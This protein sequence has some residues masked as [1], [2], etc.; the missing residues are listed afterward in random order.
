MRSRECGFAIASKLVTNTAIVKPVSETIGMIEHFSKGDR[1]RKTLRRLLSIA[2]QLQRVAALRVRANAGIVTAELVTEV[3]VT[4]HVIKCEAAP[5][6]FQRVGDIA[7]KKS[8]RPLAMIRFEQLL[9]I[10]GALRERHEFPGPVTRQSGLAPEIGVDPQAPF[11]LERPRAVPQFL[12]DFAGPGVGVLHLRTLQAAHDDK[13]R[14]EL[15]QKTQLSAQPILLRQASGQL[16][17]R[18]KMRDRF[19]IGRTAHGLIAGAHA[20]IAGGSCQ[21]GLTE[22]IGQQ[23]RFARGNVGEMFFKRV[24]DT[25][26]PFAPARQKQ[27]LIGDVTYQ[28]MLEA[29]APFLAALLGK[30]NSRRRKLRQYRLELGGPLG[31]NRRE[32][33][34]S[35]LPPDDGGNLGPFARLAEAVETGHQRILQRRRHRA[36]FARRFH[37]A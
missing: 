22:M 36:V 11:G 5:A 23:V 32:Q 31:G 33:R 20:I 29:E 12:A 30:D 3:T 4:V 28:C 21:A 37:D 13:R 19:R 24:G 35:K 6:A 8:R 2:G 16:E 10:A 26:M 34:E 14:T 17:T 9:L 18:R 7:T 27:T 15:E 25:F 1:L